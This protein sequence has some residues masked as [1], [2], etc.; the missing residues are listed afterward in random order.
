M[1]LAA[2]GSRLLVSAPIAVTRSDW[3]HSSPTN[4][5]GV[6]AIADAVGI[7]TWRVGTTA[8]WIAFVEE[9]AAST[10]DF[11]VT[12]GKISLYKNRFHMFT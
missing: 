5:S 4:G 3:R 6:L 1:I 2:F 7:S 8:L 9:D 10:Y 11:D 12:H